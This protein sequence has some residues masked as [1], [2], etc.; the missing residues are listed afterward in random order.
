MNRDGRWM[1]CSR[2][3]PCPICGKRDWCCYLDTG[4]V[5]WCMRVSSGEVAGFKRGK[6]HETAGGTSWFPTLEPPLVPVLEPTRPERAGRIKFS[7][8]HDECRAALTDDL[9]AKAIKVLGCGIDTLDAFGIGWSRHWRAW[10][11]PM[12]HAVTE[13]I[14]GIRTRTPD[15]RK[16][17]LTGSK[18]GYFFKPRH[19]RERLV[20][21]VEG[22]TDAAAMF[23]L[24]LEVIGRASCLHQSRDL[25]ER[26]RGRRVVVM[27]DN[28]EVGIAGAKKLAHYLEGFAAAWV[29][30]PPDG[31][32]D[33]REWIVAGAKRGDIESIA[34]EA[35][36]GEQEMGQQI[37][38]SAGE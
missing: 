32:K 19:G 34:W 4:E 26:L 29:I 10:T 24:G 37:Q 22:P 36:H 1:R 25:R 35:I 9:L 33:A 12:R 11:F 30:R 38:R 31:V 14:I 7:E 20:Y 3:Q 28:D 18:Q 16:F 21:I 5:F 23:S 27:A 13:Q 8:I 15:G 17:A 2:R 6:T